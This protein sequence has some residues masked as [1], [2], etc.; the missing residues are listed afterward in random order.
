MPAASRL[1]A[2]ELLKSGVGNKNHAN[3]LSDGPY[4]KRLRLNKLS[5]KISNLNIHKAAGS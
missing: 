1:A 4:F 5:D 2:L 3:A